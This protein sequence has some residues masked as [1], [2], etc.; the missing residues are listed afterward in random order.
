MRAAEG[1]EAQVQAEEAAATAAAID[2]NKAHSVGLGLHIRGRSAFKEGLTDEGDPARFLFHKALSQAAQS[3]DW[4]AAEATVAEMA[5]AGYVPGPRAYHAVVFSY[6]KARNAPGALGAIRQC[7]DAG[8]TPLPETYAAVV[9]AHVA[10]GDLD[11]AEAVCAS[12][13]RAGVDYTK[14]WQQ[15]VAALLR[16]GEQEKAAE[17]ISQVGDR[18]GSA[19]PAIASVRQAP[20]RRLTGRKWGRC[21]GAWGPRRLLCVACVPAAGRGR[22]P[23]AQRG[24]L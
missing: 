2:D 6:V 18:P 20:Q 15:L 21:P 19:A 24:N 1:V 8:I 9:A 16:L 12:N 23:A 14:S 22:A 13:R 11:T 5:Q 3:G 17:M 4:M 7:W 10:V